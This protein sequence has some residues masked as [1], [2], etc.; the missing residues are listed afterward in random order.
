VIYRFLCWLLD[1]L[2]RPAPPPPCPDKIEPKLPD[3]IS[4][5][6]RSRLESDWALREYDQLVDEWARSLDDP[7]VIENTRDFLEAQWRK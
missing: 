6:Q 3:F 5:A 1:W 4:D 2:W 7:R